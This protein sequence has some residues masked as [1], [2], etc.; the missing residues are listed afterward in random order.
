MSAGKE[1]AITLDAQEINDIDVKDTAAAAT[2]V[3][4]NGIIQN[5]NKKQRLL[6]LSIPP[7][8]WFGIDIG[9]TLVKLVYF[10][11]QDHNNFIESEEEISRRK[12]IQRYLVAN[13]TYGGT[14]VRDDHLRLCDV[15]INVGSKLIIFFSLILKRLSWEISLLVPV[16]LGA[17]N[18]IWTDAEGTSCYAFFAAMQCEKSILTRGCLCVRVSLCASVTHFHLRTYKSCGAEISRT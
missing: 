13:K 18:T 5:N 4:C 7:M 2:V 14:G 3:Q 9:G 17:V 16:H 11:P 6:S 1:R 8:P 15:E 12:K 10:E